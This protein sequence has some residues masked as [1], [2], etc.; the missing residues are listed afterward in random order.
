MTVDPFGL[1]FGVGI[2]LLSCLSAGIGIGFLLGRAYE[3][4]H[5]QR[6]RGS[7]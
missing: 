2:L 6:P 7:A 3:R 1:A 5:P 4:D